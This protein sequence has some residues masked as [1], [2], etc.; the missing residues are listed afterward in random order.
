[1]PA[2]HR[3]LGSRMYFSAVISSSSSPARADRNDDV[4]DDVV[5]VF[6]LPSLLILALYPAR[7]RCLSRSLSLSLTQPT[8]Y[9][10][11]LRNYLDIYN[12]P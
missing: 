8:I 5:V 4:D 7:S 2:Q 6:L 9:N 3:V 10:N 1:M 11:T 12:R